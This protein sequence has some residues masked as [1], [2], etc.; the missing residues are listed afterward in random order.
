M[1]LA[2]SLTMDSQLFLHKYVRFSSLHLKPDP[3]IGSNSKLDNDERQRAANG[4][5]LDHPA[6]EA[7]LLA[8]NEQSPA[9]T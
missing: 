4:N 1:R 7:D 2:S 8:H 9:L 6:I 3:D 5:A